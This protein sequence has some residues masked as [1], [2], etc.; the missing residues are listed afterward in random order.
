MSFYFKPMH[1]LR[2]SDVLDLSLVSK[3]YSFWPHITHVNFQRNIAFVGLSPK[4]FFCYEALD[5]KYRTETFLRKSNLDGHNWLSWLTTIV[6]YRDANPKWVKFLRTLTVGKE[7]KLKN[8][9]DLNMWLFNSCTGCLHLCKYVVNAFEI[10]IYIST[11]TWYDIGANRFVTGRFVT[12]TIRSCYM[13]V[14]YLILIHLL[15]DRDK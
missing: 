5:W 9:V 4:Q 6:C 2:V 11:S 15:E 1:I 13:F 7:R 12:E 8:T 3:R 14:L 10:I